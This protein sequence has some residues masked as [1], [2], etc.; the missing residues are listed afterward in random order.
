MKVSSKF[1]CIKSCSYTAS[2]YLP[3]CTKKYPILPGLIP[4]LFKKAL[5]F[6]PSD[7]SDSNEKTQNINFSIHAIT[8]FISTFLSLCHYVP[9]I[10]P[11]CYLWS[12]PSNRGVIQL[13]IFF[14]NF[15][16]FKDQIFWISHFSRPACNLFHLRL[17]FLLAS[18]FSWN[19]IRI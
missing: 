3:F 15:S 12:Y 16:Y 1:K 9:Y 2:M 6:F 4:L 18:R 7:R 17:L 8:F 14:S 10:C 19:E 13:F 11:S 5:N